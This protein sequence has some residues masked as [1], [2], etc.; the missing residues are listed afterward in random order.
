MAQIIHS[1]DNLGITNPTGGRVEDLQDHCRDGTLNNSE[2]KGGE[3][4]DRGAVNEAQPCQEATDHTEVSQRD[5]RRLTDNK[6]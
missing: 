5:D 2:N 1:E 3:Q 6:R 4:L